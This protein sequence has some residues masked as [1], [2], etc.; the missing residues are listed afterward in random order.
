[1]FQVITKKNFKMILNIKKTLLLTVMSFSVTAVTAQN[2]R[3]GYFVDDYTYRFQ[4]NPAIG[5]SKNFVSMPGLS[6]FNISENGNLHLTD[7]LYNYIPQS[8]GECIG[9]A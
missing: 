2:A 7:V 4:M 6:N 3:S 8:R 1:M 5:N 9:D